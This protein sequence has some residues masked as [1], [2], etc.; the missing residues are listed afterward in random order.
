MLIGPLLRH[1]AHFTCTARL[2]KTFAVVA[3]FASAAVA[4]N[5][6]AVWLARDNPQARQGQA[7]KHLPV[8]RSQDPDTLLSALPGDFDLG[9][10]SKGETRNVEFC[11]ENRSD[12]A[13]V[14]ERIQTSCDC[15]SVTLDAEAV[16]PR[17][18]VGGAFAVRVS[19]DD[20]FAGRLG[21]EATG[22]AKGGSAKAFVISVELRVR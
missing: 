2:F 1:L 8:S 6:A 22:V 5:R 18:T 12:F 11:L 14:I 16:G 17:E 15:L 21:L 19:E 10:L 9:E 13:V 4:A 7:D 3:M 20:E